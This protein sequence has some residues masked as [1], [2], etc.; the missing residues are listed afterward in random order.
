VLIA[1]IA[2][3]SFSD[4]CGAGR[5]LQVDTAFENYVKCDHVVT[6]RHDALLAAIDTQ[7]TNVCYDGLDGGSARRRRLA[8]ADGAPRHH[9]RLG[10]T[11]LETT[12][13]II[14]AT[15][16]LP[17]DVLSPQGIFDM[18]DVEEAIR[19][20]PGWKALCAPVGVNS[21]VNRTLLLLLLLLLLRLRPLLLLLLLLL[22]LRLL[23]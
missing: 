19:Q 22:L 18:R 16:D 7:R 8:H 12:V 14:Y 20:L 6:E 23:P 13:Q 11:Q 3:S 5:A 2:V 15:T 10:S 4:A 17:G 21:Y 1:V 9:R